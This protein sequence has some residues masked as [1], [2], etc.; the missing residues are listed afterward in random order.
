MSGC[1]YLVGAGP[2][3][4]RLL[5]V[6][7]YELVRTADV[8]A[9]DE[10]VSPEILALAPRDAERIAVG[11]RAGHGPTTFRLHPAVLERA[12]AG[13]DVVRLKC[14]DPMVFGR[15]GEEAEELAAHGITIELVPGVSAALGAAAYAGIPLTHR[16]C[17]SS[18]RFAT[19]RHTDEPRAAATERHSG[20]PPGETVVIY[21]AARRVAESLAELARAGWPASTP[22]AWIAAATTPGQRVIVGTIGNLDVPITGAP[23]LLVVGEVVARRTPW[24]ETR[25]LTTRR[26]LVARARPGRSQVAARLRALGAEVIEAPAIDIT[27]LPAIAGLVDAIDERAAVGFGCSTGVDVV[28]DRHT[29]DPQ[30]IVAFGTD[31][32]AA[33]AR[34]GIEPALSVGGACREA[35]APVAAALGQRRLVAITALRDPVTATGGR[36]A[37]LD[38]LAALGVACDALA[39]YRAVPRLPPLPPVDVIAAP[40]SSAARLV[41][42]DPSLRERPLVAMGARTAAAARAC[43]AARVELAANDTIDALVE[44]VVE[45]ARC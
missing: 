45:V 12:R 33:L 2:G 21:M 28:L 11:R 34:R 5:T 15:G 16:E 4:P 31:A 27:P 19:G 30:R 23:A 25:P 3:D 43:G 36:P 7:A 42:A 17:A 20:R 44:R 41:L 26:V 35:L 14:G 9:Y 29:I 32:A 13:R 37:L 6:R 39:A 18:V 22:V 24:W 38:E 40:S 1:V 10:L 8:L